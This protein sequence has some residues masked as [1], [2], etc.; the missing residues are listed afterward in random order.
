MR[1]LGLSHLKRLTL[2]QARP[3]ALGQSNTMCLRVLIQ[4]CPLLDLQLM[5][6]PVCRF[7]CFIHSRRVWL[8]ALAP[9]YS[10]GRFI[11]VL[12]ERGKKS[13]RSR[14]HPRSTT[15]DLKTHKQTTQPHTRERRD[16]GR[17]AATGRVGG[18]IGWGPC[19]HPHPP[20]FNPARRRRR[21]G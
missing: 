7:R 17:A 13:S 1:V 12:A 3:W 6:R 19:L 4:A 14:P 16:E 15:I 9:L 21:K 8:A 18:G 2:Q 11:C 5:R 20:F 10:R